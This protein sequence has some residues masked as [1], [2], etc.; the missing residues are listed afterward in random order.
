METEDTKQGSAPGIC[1]LAE[2]EQEGGPGLGTLGRFQEGRLGAEGK[3]VA[4]QGF[5][6]KREFKS[7]F[8]KIPSWGAQNVVN[9][10]LLHSPLATDSQVFFLSP[11]I[12]SFSYSAS[13]RA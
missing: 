8:T 1:G 13:L 12:T 7:D 4:P 3:E 6:H 2:E 10:A 5:H 9:P 11:R